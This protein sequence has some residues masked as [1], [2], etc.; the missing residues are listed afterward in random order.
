MI[1]VS[2]LATRPADV[3]AIGWRTWPWLAVAMKDAGSGG[4]ERSYETFTYMGPPDW[5]DGAPTSG[6]G[7]SCVFCGGSTVA[8]V[9]PLNSGLVQYQAHGKGHTLPTFWT[10]CESCEGVYRVGDDEVAV[11]LMKAHME[12]FCETD[13]DVEET[14]RKPI[15]V[16]RR[17]DRGGRRVVD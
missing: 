17:A 15:A 16:F 11:D 14:I 5:V 1:L 2:D 6:R 3:S 10:L 4:K 9:H 13:E 7:Q 12:G 8:W